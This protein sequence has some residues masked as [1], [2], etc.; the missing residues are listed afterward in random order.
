MFRG[1]VGSAFGEC[2][3]DVGDDDCGDH[4]EGMFGDKKADVSVFHRFAHVL[5][6]GF[7]EGADAKKSQADQ[8]LK[9]EAGGE[10]DAADA[11]GFG[12]VGFFGQADV[13]RD[14]GVNGGGE[15]DPAKEIM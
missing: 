8:E 1:G 4:Q 7:H 3:A 9:I 14:D 13:C 15:D 6:G 2:G 10:Y 11:V 5:H 12:V